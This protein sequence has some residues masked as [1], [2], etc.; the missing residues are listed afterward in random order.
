MFTAEKP[1]HE[2]ETVKQECLQRK[3]EKSRSA[4]RKIILKTTKNYRILKQ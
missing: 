2:G 1:F 4:T 3:D